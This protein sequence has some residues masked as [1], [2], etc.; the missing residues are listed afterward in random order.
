MKRFVFLL[1]AVTVWSATVTMAQNAPGS[2]AS[3][4]PKQRWQ[5]R[6]VLLCAPNNT[7]PELQAQQQQFAAA[8]SAMQERDISVREVLFEQL[9]AA[10]KQ[11]LTQK[12]GVKTSGF[13][14]LLIGKDG[15]IKRRETQPIT[16]KSLFQ[17]IDVMPMRREEARG[18]KGT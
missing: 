11:Y 7:T 12:L 15:G 13:T 4:L 17:T 1:L 18:S 14:L 9:S 6:V 5:K 2:L 16:P 10:D 3:W 8:R